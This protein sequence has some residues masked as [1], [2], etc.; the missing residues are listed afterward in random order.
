MA[1]TPIQKV[2]VIGAS[3]AVGKP[4]IQAL[5]NA[6]KF[7]VTALTRESSNSTFP[8]GV[9]VIK[10]EYSHDKLVD[11][12]RGQDA[13]LSCITTFSVNQQTPFIDAAVEAGV[14]RFLPSEYGVDTSDPSIGELVPAALAKNETVSYL[15]TKER[16]GLT[17]TAVIVGGFFDANFEYPSLY[18]FS[19]AEKKMTIFD[20]GNIEFEI[21]SLAQIGRSVVAIL[22]HP[23][24]SANQYV[25][26]NS[27][28]VTQ[29]QI[30]KALEE[31]S[32]EKFEVTQ[33]KMEDVSRDSKEKIKSDPAQGSTFIQGSFAAIMLIVMNHGGYNKYSKTK[34]LWNKR[35]GLPDEKFEDTVKAM[36][37]KAA[38]SAA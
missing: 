28:T 6:K 25:Y 26:V 34:G 3:G 33:A 8:E 30:L 12:F 22:E 37:A 29:N 18:G 23:D 24:E 2:A 32:G 15:K 1:T 36:V 7:E 13:V 35:L 17:W 21:T 16:A 31:F 9:R 14:R 27:S 5:L 4:I 10:T 11:A 20:G 19:L 38:G